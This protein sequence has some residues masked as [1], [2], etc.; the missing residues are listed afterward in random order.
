MEAEH[1]FVVVHVDFDLGEESIVSSMGVYGGGGGTNLLL[2]LVVS[3][4][5]GISNLD[6][7]AIFTSYTQKRTDHALLL[8]V[9]A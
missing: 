7:A 9:A 1:G 6:L 8:G 4:G 5:K 3:D 2:T